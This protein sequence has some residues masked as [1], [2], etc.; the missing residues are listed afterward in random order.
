MLNADDVA[1]YFL[2][3]QD[4][5]HHEPIT[6][7]KLQKLCYY[8]QGIALVALGLPLFHDHIEHWPHG[9]VVLELDRKYKSHG[10]AAIPPPTD[11]NLESYD[12]SIRALLD[13]VYR[14]Y[15]K[16]SASQLRN[17]TH[18][19]SPWMDTRPGAAISHQQ[20]REHFESLP[21]IHD[22]FPTLDREALRKMADD[23]QVKRDLKRG[24]SAMRA[25]QM[26]GWDEMK[27][28]LGIQ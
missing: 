21:T 22:Y 15:G 8:A 3:C 10:S 18:K 9:P 13:N 26:V 11:L 28:R 20:L 6:N 19:E 24:I 14:D 2:V 4:T 23:T 25:G 1:R 12:S 16:Y 17:R 27:D 7:L 5:E